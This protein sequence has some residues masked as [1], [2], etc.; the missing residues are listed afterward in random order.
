M[1]PCSRG[2]FHRKRF[3]TLFQQSFHF[4]VGRED[5]W[6]WPRS[7]LV[8]AT[9]RIL[10]FVVTGPFPF[11]AAGNTPRRDLNSAGYFVRTSAASI[12]SVAW[13]PECHDLLGSLVHVIG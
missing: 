11:L 5:N 12:S 9:K 3:S 10:E 2:P 4:G 7:L 6:F 13:R 1:I 8:R